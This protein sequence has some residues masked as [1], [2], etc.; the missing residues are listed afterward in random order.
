MEVIRVE[1]GSVVAR[2]QDKVNE[3]YLVKEGKVSQK[4]G[5]AEGRLEA[6]SM[7][8]ILDGEWFICDYVAVE[9]STLIVIPCEN[10]SELKDIL[11]VNET[12]RSVFLQA[13]LRQRHRMLSLYGDLQKKCRRFQVVIGAAFADYKTICNQLLVQE[14][15]DVRLEYFE[16]LEVQHKVDYW[17]I[18]YSNSLVQIYMR[19]YLYL[20]TRDT[21]LCVGA[22]MEASA[23]MH[24]VTQG[25]REMV[26]FLQYNKDILFSE[27]E[28]D[29]YHM[30][31]QMAKQ[32]A[33][34]NMDSS[35]IQENMQSMIEL[36]QQLNVYDENLVR[37]CVN[38][39]TNY[40]FANAHVEQE[41]GLDKD[42]LIQ[43]LSYGGFEVEEI[44]KI[45]KMVQDY[46]NLP[47]PASTDHAAYQI[48]KQ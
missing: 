41:S 29:L 27:Y 42:C 18:S 15:S 20:M 24:R 30:Y 26:N 21:G 46:K 22:I 16:P 17:E 11:T 37:R 45:R 43:I 31:F 33:Q 12:Y 39:F 3:W 19:D 5:F 32:A 8:G 36:I 40:D 47:D 4:F 7:I 38:T 44:E 2:R 1:K 48:R 14:Q 25:I 10:A 35:L 34:K 23:Q 9:D 6:N 13:A 28:T